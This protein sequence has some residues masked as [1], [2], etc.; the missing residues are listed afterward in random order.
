M[1]FVSV[2]CRSRVLIAEVKHREGRIHR[3]EERYPS[4]A[5]RQSDGHEGWTGSSESSIEGEQAT[6][7]AETAGTG[8]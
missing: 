3:E 5:K 6:I 8:R 7:S 4:Q 2:C 1:R